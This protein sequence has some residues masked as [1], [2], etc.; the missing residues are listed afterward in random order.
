MST[1]MT[2]N[3]QNGVLVNFS[4]FLAATRISRVNCAEMAGDRPRQPA[5]SMK[6]SALN[7]DFSN[8]SPDFLYSRRPVHA[9]VSERF[10]S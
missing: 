4:R 10:P 7:V 6:F 1:L 5:Y 9:G 2:L 3:P 8:L